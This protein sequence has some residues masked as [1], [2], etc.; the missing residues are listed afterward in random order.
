[1]A[2]IVSEWSGARDDWFCFVFL[3]PPPDVDSFGETNCL[4]TGKRSSSCRYNVN[5]NGCYV[6]LFIS[7]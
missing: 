6:F 7:H 2:V 4:S 1:M 5:G 3:C